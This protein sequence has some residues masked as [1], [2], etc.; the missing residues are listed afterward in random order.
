[1]SMAWAEDGF[2]MASRGAMRQPARMHREAWLIF[3]VLAASVG[4][5]MFG[6]TTWRKNE[7]LALAQTEFA[8]AREE[9]GRARA[10]VDGQ[11]SRLAEVQA[12]LGAAQVQAERLTREMSQATNNQQRLEA[13]MRTA[14]QSRDVAISEL[15]GRL[16]VNILDRIL[17]DSGEAQVKPEGMK[18]LDQVAGVL[19]GFTNRQIQVFGHTDNRPI[20]LKYP[21]NWELSMARAVAAVRYLSERAGVDPRRLAAVGCGEFQPIADNATPEGRA[22]NRRIALVVLPEQF[23][24]TDVTGTN[25]PPVVSSGTNVPPVVPAG[26]NAVPAGPISSNAPVRADPPVAPEAG[27]VSTHLPLAERPGSATNPPPVEAN[28]PAPPAPPV[29]EPEAKAPVEEPLP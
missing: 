3:A 13:E 9:L 19:A 21:S 7:A 4:L 8:R 27:V 14:L 18:V 29:P 10:E 11:R 26:T 25:V 15:Q 6:M 5:G 2:G 24:P 16:T 12:S 17:F 20:R 28:L 23:V 1:M 22:R